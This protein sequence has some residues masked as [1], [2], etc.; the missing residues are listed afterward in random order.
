M[1][2]TRSW[3]DDFVSVPTDDPSN[4]LRPSKG[5]ATRSK[6]GTPSSQHSVALS[7]ERFLTWHPTQ[8]LTRYV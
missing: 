7:L 6:R 5:L 3:I 4:C 2:L 1:K 8:M